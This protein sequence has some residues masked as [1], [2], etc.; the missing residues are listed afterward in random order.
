[1]QLTSLRQENLDLV[2]DVR[3]RGDRIAALE[4]E[5]RLAKDRGQHCGSAS[6]FDKENTGV[7]ARPPP[8]RPTPLR[9]KLQGRYDIE[10]ATVGAVDRR[11]SQHC[12][13]HCGRSQ[14]CCAV[15]CL[16]DD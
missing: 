11:S 3:V 15:H 16:R 1:M 2:R 4:E 5:L 8:K 7:K 9:N 14:R 12:E 6:A 13:Y 10:E